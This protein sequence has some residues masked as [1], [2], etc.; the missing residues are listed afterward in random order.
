M[1]LYV[2][3]PKN[4][5]LVSEVAFLHKHTK[6]F[7]ATDAVVYIPDSPSPLFST[8][9]DSDT[10]REPEFWPQT[11]LQLVFLPVWKDDAG[12]PS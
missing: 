12:R 1:T 10:I 2:N 7:A 6:T 9:F 8:Y 11:V 4:V 5:G 3:M